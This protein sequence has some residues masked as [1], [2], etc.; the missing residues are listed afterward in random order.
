M[1]TQL[2]K[3]LVNLYKNQTGRHRTYI[4][5]LL[6]RTAFSIVGGTGFGADPG[7]QLGILKNPANIVSVNFMKLRRE[8]CPVS[9]PWYP[10]D[11]LQIL[12][13]S[14]FHANITTWNEDE[15]TQDGRI[16]E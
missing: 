8:H 14:F 4:T 9:A 12:G 15:L 1:G 2:L 13:K 7:E 5:Y 10:G 6:L 16:G 3:K 11:M